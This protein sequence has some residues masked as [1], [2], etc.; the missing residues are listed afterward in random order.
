MGE[1]V[2]TP[3]FRFI[4]ESALLVEYGEVLDDAIH[5]QVLALDAAISRSRLADKVETLPTF[6][7]LLIRFDLERIKPY[8]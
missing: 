4:N 1:T 2:R 3:A 6:R 8:Q 5:N 7:S